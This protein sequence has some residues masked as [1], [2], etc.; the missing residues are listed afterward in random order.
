MKTTNHITATLQAM[1]KAMFAKASKENAEIKLTDDMLDGFRELASQQPAIYPFFLKSLPSSAEVAS[2]FESISQHENDRMT[3]PDIPVAYFKIIS[4]ER[5]SLLPHTWNGK[6]MR[7]KR[8][9]SSLIMTSPQQNVL[10]R[11]IVIW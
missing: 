7:T 4:K 11:Y 2:Y 1:M 10:Q 8:R 3:M 5:I 9:T 6:L